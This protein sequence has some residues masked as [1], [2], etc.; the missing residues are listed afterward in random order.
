[1]FDNNKI[2]IKKINSGILENVVSIIFPAKTLDNK[3]EEIFLKMIP[4]YAWNNRENVWIAYE[5]LKKIENSN[6]II[7]NKHRGYIKNVYLI[8]LFV[9]TYSFIKWN[10]KNEFTDRYLDIFQ[11]LINN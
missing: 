10:M 1:M 4:Y 7:K 11:P 6:K 3:I 9:I 5:G 8:I 2:K